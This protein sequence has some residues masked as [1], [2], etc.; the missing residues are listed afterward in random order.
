MDENTKNKQKRI[1]YCMSFFYY[2]RNFR[3][4]NNSSFAIQ[5]ISLELPLSLMPLLP[6]LPILWAQAF[7]W[8]SLWKVMNVCSLLSNIPFQKKNK[9]NRRVQSCTIILR[10]VQSE[11]RISSVTCSFHFYYFITVFPPTFPQELEPPAISP[12]ILPGKPGKEPG[13]RRGI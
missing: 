5:G 11:K 13:K 7:Y 10:Q 4:Q 2:Y 9:A 12:V 6:L 1:Q 8:S 3:C